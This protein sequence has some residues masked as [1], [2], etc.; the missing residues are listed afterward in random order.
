MPA[1]DKPM[2]APHHARGRTADHAAMLAM[3]ISAYIPN[4]YTQV[5]KPQIRTFV[6]PPQLTIWLKKP[7]EQPGPQMFI[8]DKYPESNSPMMFAHRMMIWFR[9]RFIGV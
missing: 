5:G 9:V 7:C 1:S 2:S 4:P 6:G 3:K 8:Y